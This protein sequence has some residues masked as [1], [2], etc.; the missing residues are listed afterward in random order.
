MQYVYKFYLTA[1]YIAFSHLHIMCLYNNTEYFIAML[2][3]GFSNSGTQEREKE[4]A[5][6]IHFVDFLDECEGTFCTRLV[7]C[8]HKSLNDLP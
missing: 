3:A 1:E 5:C 2:K 8:N 7:Q 6:F 4:E